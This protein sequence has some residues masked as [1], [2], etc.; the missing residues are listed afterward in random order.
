MTTCSNT[1]A[2]TN[3]CDGHICSTALQFHNYR[4][5]SCIHFISPEAQG[6]VIGGKCEELRMD[7]IGRE[8]QNSMCRPL[9]TALGLLSITSFSVFAQTK[10]PG[11]RVRSQTPNSKQTMERKAEEEN[12]REAVFRSLIR[13]SDG[14][15]CKVIFLAVAD[16]NSPSSALM[17][18]F[19]SNPNSCQTVFQHCG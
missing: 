17:T 9:L 8:G 16:Q 12:I 4:Q 6:E 5:N 13:H 11:T 14:G 2:P 7:L 3:Y 19:A 18:R 15:V 10:H 1:S